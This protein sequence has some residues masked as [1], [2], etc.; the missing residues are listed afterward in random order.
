MELVAA[1]EDHFD[2]ALPLNQ[3][4]QLK[5]ID[6]VVDRIVALAESAPVAAKS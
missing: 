5:T 2:V 4:P 6:Q 1:L 3:L